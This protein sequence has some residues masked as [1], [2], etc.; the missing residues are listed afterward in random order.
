MEFL[1]IY[2]I[3]FIKNFSLHFL[4]IHT[5]KNELTII[6]ILVHEKVAKQILLKWF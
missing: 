5:C 3:I 4:D 2:S 6:F 1:N